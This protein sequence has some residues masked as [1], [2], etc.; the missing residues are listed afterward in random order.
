MIVYKLFSLAFVKIKTGIIQCN[1]I[2]IFK[3]SPYGNLSKVSFNYDIKPSLILIDNYKK[4]SVIKDNDSI[5]P[6]PIVL[7][8]ILI[9]NFFNFTNVTLN[10][11]LKC[12][13]SHF[14]QLLPKI[15]CGVQSLLVILHSAFTWITW[16]SPRQ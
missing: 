5:S 6:K 12:Q 13:F 7:V 2:I 11:S 16:G 3:P 14:H 1:Q 4:M 15:A 9:L 10:F 8:S